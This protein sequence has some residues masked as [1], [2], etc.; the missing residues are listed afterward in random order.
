MLFDG[1]FFIKPAMKGIQVQTIQTLQFNSTQM[2]AVVSETTKLLPDLVDIVSQFVDYSKALEP[3]AR[4][5]SGAPL[6]SENNRLIMDATD[7]ALSDPLCPRE[8]VNRIFTNFIL[9]RKELNQLMRSKLEKGEVINLDNT[10]VG[11]PDFSNLNMTEQF[12]AVNAQMYRPSFRNT[13]LTG[14]NLGNLDVFEPTIG[15]MVVTGANLDGCNL[16][17][18]Y[19]AHE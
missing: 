2:K 5:E 17:N 18:N 16:E 9:H 13:N 1:A 8:I 10:K 6:D 11:Y 14:T 4:D 19:L 15:G 12:S 7:S 3:L